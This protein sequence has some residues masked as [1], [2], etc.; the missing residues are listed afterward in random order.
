VSVSHIIQAYDVEN[1]SHN[2]C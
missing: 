1:A 2:K